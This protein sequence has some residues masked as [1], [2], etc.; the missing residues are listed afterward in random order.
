MCTMRVALLVNNN[1]DWTDI[2]RP[3][4]GAWIQLASQ[5]VAE[6]W[7]P[8][9]HTTVLVAPQGDHEVDHGRSWYDRS[10]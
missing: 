5:L 3:S 7:S 10:S 8:T 1:L 4:K 9:T 2:V 6:G